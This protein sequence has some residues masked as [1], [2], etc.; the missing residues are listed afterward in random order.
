MIARL[1]LAPCC[2]LLLAAQAD[3]APE[4]LRPNIEAICTELVKDRAH[5][6][7]Q[8][9]AEEELAFIAVLSWLEQNGLLGPDGAIDTLALLEGQLDPLLAASQTPA[10]A[11]SFCFETAAEWIALQQCLEAMAS[12]PG[13]GP[14]DPSLAPLYGN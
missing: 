4:P 5:L 14:L 9:R 2:L 11:A 3:L 1:V 6:M 12:A 10:A 13:F 7:D 8:C